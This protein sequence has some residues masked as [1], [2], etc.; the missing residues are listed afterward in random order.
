M[1]AKMPMK[2]AAKLPANKAVPA[3]AK[4]TFPPTSKS[5]KKK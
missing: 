1:K 4:F 2:D 3:K 5:T